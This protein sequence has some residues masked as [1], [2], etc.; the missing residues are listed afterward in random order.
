MDLLNLIKT[1][2][3]EYLKFNVMNPKNRK[4]T[5]LIKEIIEDHRDEVGTTSLETF[6]SSKEL[7]LRNH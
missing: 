7:G 2:V 3:E 1:K 6:L 4:A 5:D